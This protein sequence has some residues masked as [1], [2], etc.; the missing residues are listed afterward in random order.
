MRK[1]SHQRITKIKIDQIENLLKQAEATDVTNAC[2]VQPAGDDLIPYPD[3]NN[4]RNYTRDYL[5]KGITKLYPVKHTDDGQTYLTTIVDGLPLFTKMSKTI[6]VN[7]S[8]DAHLNN[9]ISVVGNVIIGNTGIASNFSSSSYLSIGLPF[10]NGDSVQLK[11]TTGSD[12]SNNFDLLFGNPISSIP[13]LSGYGGTLNSWYL[14]KNIVIPS[15]VYA[16]N[17]TLYVKI[18]RESDTSCSFSYSTDGSSYT[19]GT[20]TETYSG[21]CTEIRLGLRPDGTEAWNGTIDLHE[22]YVTLNGKQYQLFFLEGEEGT[23]QIE[24]SKP[25]LWLSNLCTPVYGSNAGGFLQNNLI[26]NNDSNFDLINSDIIGNYAYTFTQRG[27]IHRTAGSSH[28]DQDSYNQMW[29]PSALSCISYE[30]IIIPT[31]LFQQ[32]YTTYQSMVV[33]SDPNSQTYSESLSKSVT[34]NF[35]DNNNADPATSTEYN[36]RFVGTDWKYELKFTPN[37]NGSGNN[38]GEGSNPEADDGSNGGCIT[39][40]ITHYLVIDGVYTACTQ[41]VN[42]CFR[43]DNSFFNSNVP[44]DDSDMLNDPNNPWN[45]PYTLVDNSGYV[46]SYSIK[47]P[48]GGA[49]IIYSPKVASCVKGFKGFTHGSNTTTGTSFQN[50][51]Y[52]NTHSGGN[53]G[54]YVDYPTGI[55]DS[56]ECGYTC[57]ISGKLFP[58]TTYKWRQHKTIESQTGVNIFLII[59][60]LKAE[61]EANGLPWTGNCNVPRFS[62]SFSTEKCNDPWCTNLVIAKNVDINNLG[63][64]SKLN[65]VVFGK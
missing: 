43:T 44:Q 12:I 15:S 25:G 19:S 28:Y 57:Y 27:I 16:A 23:T 13:S 21:T 9:I 40:T 30:A 50:V 46:Q 64:I 62:F 45:G 20:G 35:I 58:G 47:F 51:G 24:T 17:K 22:S 11:F 41:D 42:S 65:E 38:Y 32:T 5:L 26:Y 6:E 63:D 8:Q 48:S 53:C 60:D 10:N 3:M 37:G 14:T 54:Y 34:Y 31:D 18:T 56:N 7:T 36:G 4:L 52:G 61:Y 33:P 1:Y 59:T 29:S 49:D 2:S 55:Y 39:G